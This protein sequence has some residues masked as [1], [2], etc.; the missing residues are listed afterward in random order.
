VRGGVLV[1]SECGAIRAGD[2]ADGDGELE[3]L[4]FGVITVGDGV[5]SFEVE[6]SDE[7]HEVSRAIWSAGVGRL[8]IGSDDT[9][10]Q[11]GRKGDVGAV[12][13]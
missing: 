7:A 9:I 4:A 11:E 5:K 6:G 2:G 1:S 13:G 3:V 8:L 12:L 10:T